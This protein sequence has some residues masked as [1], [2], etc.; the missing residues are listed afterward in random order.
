VDPVAPPGAGGAAQGSGGGAAA[1]SFAGRRDRLVAALRADAVTPD[2]P[3]RL[4]KDTS[5][6]FRDRHAAPRRRLDVRAFDHVLRVDARGG[7]VESEGMVSYSALVDATLASGTMPC[8]VPQ[9][10]SITL[11]GAVAGVGI[12]AS[13]FRHGLV[14][15]TV[16]EL[17]VLLADGSTVVARADNEHRDLF[18]GFPNSYGTLGYALRVVAR[19]RPVLRFVRL[20]HRRFDDAARFFGELERACSGDADFVEGVVFGPRDFVLS[21]AHFA[22]DAPFTSDYTFERIYWKS[23]REREE[24]WLT[25]RDYLWRWDTDWF[26]CS[27]NLFAQHRLVRRLIGRDRLNSVFYARVMRLNSR[28]GVTRRLERL[29]GV[30]PESVIQDVDVPIGRAAEFLSFLL[31]EIG[32]LPVWVC[33]FRAADP[34]RHWT[35]FP[36]DAGTRYLNFG[37]WDVV[38]SR[39]AHPPGHFNRLVE[40]EVRR[41]GGIK[42]LYSESFFGPEEFREIYAG[43]AYDALKARYDPGGLLPTLYEKTVLRH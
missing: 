38:R 37:F 22:A 8:V 33:P 39:S 7:R 10:K 11:G 12:E 3:L 30:H 19:T 15:E 28:I 31:A 34:Q 35:L 43:P 2:A 16:D 41:L 32:I 42:S 18:F 24:D 14:H 25:T 29:R 13:S 23:L 27:K 17:E 6:L 9:L 21:V 20:R 1:D 40:R 36:I 4:R 26:W 5:N